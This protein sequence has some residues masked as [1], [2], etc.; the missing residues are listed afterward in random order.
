MGRRAWKRPFPPPGWDGPGGR[1]GRCWDIERLWLARMLLMSGRSPAEINRVPSVHLPELFLFLGLPQVKEDPDEVPADAFMQMLRARLSEMEERGVGMEE[2]PALS[3]RMFCER[4]ALSETEA[5]VLLFAVLC[6][7]DAVFKEVASH[8]AGGASSS[9]LSRFLSGVIGRD[10]A[11]LGAAIARGAP[12]VKMRVIR[13]VGDTHAERVEFMD[14]M[15]GLENVLLQ[16]YADADTL[17]GNFFGRSP[18][19]KLSADDFP[20]LREK[21]DLLA[22]FLGSALREGSKGANVMLYGLP[23]TGKT[24]LARLLSRAAG[25]G[26]YEVRVTDSGDDGISGSCRFSSFQLCQRLLERS[27]DALVLF[28]ECEDVFPSEEFGLFGIRRRS[29]NEKGFTNHLLEENPVPAKGADARDQ[30]GRPGASCDAR[31]RM[32]RQTRPHQKDRG[33]LSGRL[34]AEGRRMK[35][36]KKASRQARVQGA[37]RNAATKR[38]ETVPGSRRARPADEANHWR[39][40]FPVLVSLRDEDLLGSVLPQPSVRRSVSGPGAAGGR[41]SRD[42]ALARPVGRVEHGRRRMAPQ[43]Y[44]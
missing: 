21:I 35:D 7:I 14:V 2:P 29:G 13:L 4:L 22:R 9:R 33:V 11:Q 6:K 42:G 1:E 34:K 43:T 26:M 44:C 36:Q 32:P 3:V 20:H 37:E 23:G 25:A 10:P 17:L 30:A 19:P 18:E 28:D 39:T 41:G 31:D 24:E 40:G 8:V 5:D 15:D 38:H 16:E 27:H 12:L